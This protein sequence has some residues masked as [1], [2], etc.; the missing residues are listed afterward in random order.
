MEDAND[1]D[2]IRGLAVK[3]EVATNW[4]IPK[5]RSQVRTG[6]TKAWIFGEKGTFR[7]NSLE[8]L[9][10]GMGIVLRDVAPYFDKVLFGAGCSREF[11][12]G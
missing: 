5:V 4:K 12:Q 2:A 7:I 9:I 10:G 1:F 6:W 11:R 8:H 3:N